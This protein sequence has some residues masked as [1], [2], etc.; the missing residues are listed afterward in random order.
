[1]CYNSELAQK[2]IK[3]WFIT[4]I[5]MDD[6]LLVAF[7]AMATTVGFPETTPLMIVSLSLAFFILFAFA[8]WA[9]CNPYKKIRGDIQY[10][11]A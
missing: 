2:I 7:I 3:L 6:I 4:A 1:M 9:G 11:P 10:S 8:L 5:V